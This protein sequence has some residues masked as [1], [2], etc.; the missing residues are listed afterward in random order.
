MN[1]SVFF[2]RSAAAALA[3]AFSWPCAAAV[4][5][6]DKAALEEFLGHKVPC[7]VIDARSDASRQAAPLANALVYR[8]GLKINPTGVVVVVADS[9]AKAIEI[10]EILA[11]AS[12][13]KEVYAVQGGAPTW[14]AVS[15]GRAFFGRP[16]S[17]IIPSNTCEQG[18]P[19]QEL[20]S[21]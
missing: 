17:F 5:L 11:G 15:G 10:G 9:D 14:Q 6:R 8:K 4:T 21:E 19:L 2:L 13:A 18:K 12:K 1:P 20:R 3:L 7:C 16:R